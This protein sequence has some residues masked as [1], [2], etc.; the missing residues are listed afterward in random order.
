MASPSYKDCKD[1]R[2]SRCAESY[3][4]GHTARRFGDEASRTSRR[5]H[6]GRN[7]LPVLCR[8]VKLQLHAHLDFQDVDELLGLDPGIWEATKPVHDFAKPK[9][10]RIF[11]PSQRT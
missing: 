11:L 5:V 4:L 3:I 7:D 6:F 9:R 10:C 2:A 1:S 8:S